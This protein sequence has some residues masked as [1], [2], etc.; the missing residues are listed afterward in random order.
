[1]PPPWMEFDEGVYELQP[2]AGTA[3]PWLYRWNPEG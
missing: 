2:V 1:M 3:T